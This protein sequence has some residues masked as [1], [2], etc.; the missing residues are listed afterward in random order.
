[1][2]TSRVCAARSAQR[3]KC[4]QQCGGCNFLIGERRASR[5]GAFHPAFSDR[6]IMSHI[7]PTSEFAVAGAPGVIVDSP[8]PSRRLPSTIMILLIIFNL[9][10]VVL[11]LRAFS[12]GIA[13][14][15]PLMAGLFGISLPLGMLIKF[16][17]VSAG[18]ILLW[19][20]R[21]LPLA[22]RGMNILAFAYGAVVVYHV[23]FQLAA[24]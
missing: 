19:K 17:A 22:A 10:D 16:I 1:M 3:D 12:L 11:T 2:S 5:P 15:N 20:Y 13:E 24:F 18:A 4:S 21:Y 6:R 8:H 14:A 9:L 7:L 23:F